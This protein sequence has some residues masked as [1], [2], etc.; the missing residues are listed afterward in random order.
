MKRNRKPLAIVA[1][2]NG[3]KRTDGKNGQTE[4]KNKRVKE[5]E[6]PKKKF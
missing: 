5:T 2:M 4:R 3:W 1:K 6:A